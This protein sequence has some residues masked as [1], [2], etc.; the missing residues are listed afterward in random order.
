VT[1]RGFAFAEDE[2]YFLPDDGLNPM[3]MTYVL[4]GETLDMFVPHTP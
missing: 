2:F 1:R 3:L 4:E